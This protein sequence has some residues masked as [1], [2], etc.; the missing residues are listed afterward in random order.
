[1]LAWL[2][3]VPFRERSGDI[4]MQERLCRER[5]SHNRG[6]CDMP[7]QNELAMHHPQRTEKIY[8]WT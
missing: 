5:V 1:M 8:E 3:A 4:L 6:F 2:S 7:A